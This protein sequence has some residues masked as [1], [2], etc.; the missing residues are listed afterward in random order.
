MVQGYCCISA[1]F[2][3]PHHIDTS[4]SCSWTYPRICWHA[5][6]RKAK[7]PGARPESYN[8]K[9]SCRRGDFAVAKNGTFNRCVPPGRF[10]APDA[11]RNF[12]LKRR[13]TEREPFFFDLVDQ[14]PL[15]F[16]AELHQPV[17]RLSLGTPAGRDDDVDR[18]AVPC[19]IRRQHDH[20]GFVRT[21]PIRQRTFG[22]QPSANEFAAGMLR[23]FAVNRTLVSDAER[24]G[25]SRPDPMPTHFDLQPAGATCRAASAA[26]LAYLLHRLNHACS[27]GS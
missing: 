21:H 25:V 6:D 9:L 8:L 24:T 12:R 11:R 26:S 27:P 16:G 14:Q 23:A 17:Q 15:V 4:W 5:T 20:V 3:S 7:V 18:Q 13:R 10:A 22:N 19:E 2:R 1:F